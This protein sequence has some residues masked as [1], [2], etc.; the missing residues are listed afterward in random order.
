MPTEADS[1]IVIDRKLRARQGG[2]SKTPIKSPPK[3]LLPMVAPIMFC[4]IREA[5]RS[6]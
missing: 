3:N 6:R 5:A 2:T 1:R 4:S